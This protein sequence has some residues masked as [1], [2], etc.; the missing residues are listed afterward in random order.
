MMRLVQLD[1]LFADSHAMKIP[2]TMMSILRIILGVIVGLAGL[3]LLGFLLG[4]LAKYAPSLVPRLYV[5][6]LAWT[7]S[8]YGVWNVFSCLR[9]GYA[10]GGRWGG[11]QRSASPFLFWC[12]VLFFSF[13]S[14]VGFTVGVCAILFNYLFH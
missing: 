6:I 5:L 7:Y 10:G 14:I 1:K 8:G 13:I 3:L 2:K 4:R 11:Y 9:Y 12:N